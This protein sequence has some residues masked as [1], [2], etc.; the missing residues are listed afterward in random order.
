MT[1]RL[2]RRALL[3]WMA[4][5]GLTLP[6]LVHQPLAAEPEATPRDLEDF[7][8]VVLK[9][10][11]PYSQLDD[12]VYRQ[13]AVILTGAVEADPGLQALVV[14]GQESLDAG[15]DGPWLERAASAQTAALGASADTAFFR[16]VRGLGGLVFYS[17]PEVWQLLG[18]EG[19]SFREGGYLARGFDDIDWLPA[20]VDAN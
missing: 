17:L 8:A 5:T 3:R 11:F 16:V 12:S 18:Y 19:P 1:S 2:H 6:V 9:R 15:G 4:T 20:A 10:L 14:A 13:S 7:L